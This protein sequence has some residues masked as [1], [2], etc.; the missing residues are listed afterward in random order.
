MRPLN[1]QVH[2]TEGYVSSPPALF[3]T[4][5]QNQVFTLSERMGSVWD[6]NKVM[7]EFVFEVL[8]NGNRTGVFASRIEMRN[9]KVRVFTKTGWKNWS[10]KQFI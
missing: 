1:Q 3:I 8:A 10:G 6:G 9:G 7:G 5:S 2:I 4:N